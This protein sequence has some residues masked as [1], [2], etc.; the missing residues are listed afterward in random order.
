MQ[1]SWRG[2]AVTP[3]YSGCRRLPTSE[4]LLSRPAKA[5]VVAAETDVLHAAPDSV[6][7]CCP[8]I[9]HFP[10]FRSADFSPQDRLLSIGRA[11]PCIKER[12]LQSAGPSAR[13]K[14]GVVSSSRRT[15]S[16]L[17]RFDLLS[18]V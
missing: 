9:N 12:G 3:N 13:R 1:S 7:I 4:R 16:G 15:Q 18:I 17:L 5:G 14:M 11:F 8:S 2:K 6:S 10:P